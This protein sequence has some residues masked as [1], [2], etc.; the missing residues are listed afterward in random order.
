M[1]IK[2]IATGSSGNAYILT[3]SK[4]KHLL[5][6]AGLTIKEIKQ[7]LDFDIGNVEGCVI[8]HSH[9]DHLKSASK[10][11]NMGI[12]VFR[13]YEIDKDI[14]KTQIGSFTVTSFPVPHNGTP[15]RAFV[16]KADGETILYATDF[17]YI[18]YKMREQRFTAM[19]VECNYQ[20]DRITTENGHRDHVFLGHCELSTCRDFVSE[21]VTDALKTIILIH[22]SQSGGLDKA[23]AVNEIQAVAPGTK[24]YMAE[25]GLTVDI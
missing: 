14:L 6:D 20:A 1:R 4:G 21:N 17:E 22:P 8:S 5:L 13:P 7:G 25:K 2:T 19:L 11:E 15:N 3:T 9:Q 12:R 10:I 18:P 23:R 16:I 24:V